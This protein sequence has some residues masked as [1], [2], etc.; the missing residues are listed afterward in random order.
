[1]PIATSLTSMFDF[2]HK[3]A[4]SLINVILVAKKA[5]DAYLISSADLLEVWKYLPPFLIKGRYNFF[6]ILFALLLLVPTTTLS[7]NWKSLIASPSLKNSGLDTTSNLFLFLFDFKIFVI[8]S[9]VV[10]GTVDL[11]TII[12]YLFRLDLILFTT[13]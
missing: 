11:V 12:L 9:P 10:T 5:F 1:M 3:L 8:L 4:I 13:L 2:S 6:K 7:G